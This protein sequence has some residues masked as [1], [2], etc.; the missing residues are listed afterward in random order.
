M[1]S[2]GRRQVVSN[3]LACQ[4]AGS[5]STNSSPKNSRA[6]FS[7]AHSAVNTPAAAGAWAGLTFVVTGEVHRF[8]NRDALKA[9][10]AAEGGKV[11]GSV[12][13]KT[14]FLINN[15]VASTSGKNRKAKDLGVPVI[16]E[17]EFIARFGS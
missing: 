2:S 15:D 7:E 10:V 11:T 8:A 16:S 1:R 4:F 3:F 14:D 13:A 9:Y 5:V 6:N 12:S 17:D